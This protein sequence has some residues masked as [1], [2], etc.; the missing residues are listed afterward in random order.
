MYL[1]KI[2]AYLGTKNKAESYFVE[3]TQKFPQTQEYYVELFQFYIQNQKTTKAKQTA[4]ILL[5]KFPSFPER[6]LLE[7]FI[8]GNLPMNSK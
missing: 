7:D 5:Q 1:A 6:T 2:Y 8:K 4:I 3:L